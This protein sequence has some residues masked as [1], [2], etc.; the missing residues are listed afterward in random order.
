MR[1]IHIWNK[2]ERVVGKSLITFCG[3]DLKDIPVTEPDGTTHYAI[4]DIYRDEFVP[5]LCEKCLE[6]EGAQMVLLAGT[7]L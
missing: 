1:I 3:T 5:D 2:P 6:Y 4:F 7:E